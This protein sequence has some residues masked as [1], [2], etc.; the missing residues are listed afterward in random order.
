MFTNVS[1]SN[2]STFVEHFQSTS[3]LLYCHNNICSYC[4][5]FRWWHQY[6]TLW[7]RFFAWTSWPSPWIFKIILDP[8]TRNWTW[9]TQNS[10]HN[11]IANTYPSQIKT[12]NFKGN[13]FSSPPPSSWWL[14]RIL[15]LFNFIY[16]NIFNSHKFKIKIVET[17]SSWSRVS[18]HNTYGIQSR[19]TQAVFYYYYSMSLYVITLFV[20][21]PLCQVCL[22]TL[23]SINNYHDFFWKINQN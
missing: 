1:L 2:Y 11:S 18:C 8:C 12:C 22:S 19:K 5:L 4:A 15:I 17:F 23:V 10:N 13:L 16:E 20:F 21:Y 14:S 9:N 3:T 6:W 7:F